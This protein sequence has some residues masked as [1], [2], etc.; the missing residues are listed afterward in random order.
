MGYVR[1]EVLFATNK[2][3]LPWLHTMSKSENTFIA[4]G[5]EIPSINEINPITTR[6]GLCYKPFMLLTH[7]ID[8]YV[9]IRI[10]MFCNNSAFIPMPRSVT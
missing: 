4:V 10:N 2:G 6:H 5:A 1:L 7:C 3:Y 9:G 8:V